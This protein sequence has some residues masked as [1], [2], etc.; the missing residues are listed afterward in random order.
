MTE[1]DRQ[2]DDLERRASDR[3]GRDLRA[4]FEPPGS[5][6]AQTER[7][8]REQIHRHLGRP[9]QFVIGLRWAA[10]ATAAAALI[11]V[12][13]MVHKARGPVRPR[14]ADSRVAREWISPERHAGAGG[15]ADIDSNGRVDVLDAFCLAKHVESRGPIDARYDLNGDGLVNRDDVDVVA[16]AA[17]RLDKGV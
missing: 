13:V 6:P 5:V 11:A 10:A 8:I 15:R 14:A 16:F 4:L 3:L 12:A 17:V 1:H 7:A 9:R 2:F